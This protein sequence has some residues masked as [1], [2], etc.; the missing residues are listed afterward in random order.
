MK[1]VKIWGDKL[2]QIAEIKVYKGKFVI[3]RDGEFF[4]K[5]FPK[6]EWDGAS[7]FHNM[8]LEALGIANSQSPEVMA[9]VEGGGKME[10]ELYDDHAECILYGKSTIYGRY[11]PEDVDVQKLEE[12]VKDIFHLEVPVVI[13]PAA[14]G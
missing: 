2:D 1:E 8:I 12:A 7:F 13:Y 6:S 5:L 10:V 4:A 14:E 9:Q 3:K 11:N